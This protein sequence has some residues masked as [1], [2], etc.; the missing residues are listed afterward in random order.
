MAFVGHIV[1][2]INTGVFLVLGILAAA[3]G[4]WWSQFGSGLGGGWGLTALIFEFPVL[5]SIPSFIIGIQ[6]L[7]T[8]DAQKMLLLIFFI[9][10]LFISFAFILIAHSIDPCT[11]SIWTLADRWGTQP[12]CERF[13][14]DINIHT[15]FHLIWHV[16]P[17]FVL[18]VPYHFLFRK[19]YRMTQTEHGVGALT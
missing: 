5:L 16:A 7:F 12:L 2:W 10:P 11:L 8:K 4:G 17:I 9:G 19:I 1:L 18:L 3:L 6:G 13:G 15:R 14:S